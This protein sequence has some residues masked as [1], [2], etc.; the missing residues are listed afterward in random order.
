MRVRVEQLPEAGRVALAALADLTGP[1]QPVW[2]VGDNH[3]PW[4]IFVRVGSAGSAGQPGIKDGQFTEALEWESD[5]AVKPDPKD[6]RTFPQVII[7][8]PPAAKPSVFDR[9]TRLFS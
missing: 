6:G 3:K 5:L 1:S 8:A 7:S 4:P 2:V 9:P